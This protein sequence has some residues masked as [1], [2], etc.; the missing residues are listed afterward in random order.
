MFLRPKNKIRVF[1]WFW[2]RVKIEC[3]KSGSGPFI[4][5]RVEIETGVPKTQIELKIG[6]EIQMGPKTRDQT[7]KTLQTHWIQ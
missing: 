6:P 7:P 1:G 3:S 5:F 4:G 2:A